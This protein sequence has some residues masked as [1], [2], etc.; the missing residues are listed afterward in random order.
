MK[1]VTKAWICAS[2]S[3]PSDKPFFT[4]FSFDPTNVE[5][6]SKFI[7][8]KACEWIEEVPDDI[9]I[10]QEVVNA[11][12][13]EIQK[14][15]ADCANRITELQRQISEWTAIGCEVAS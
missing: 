6:G 12:E 5:G 14:A 11:M 4:S 8:I 2:Q 3:T 13:R 9:D 10:R 1:V 7:V 15:R